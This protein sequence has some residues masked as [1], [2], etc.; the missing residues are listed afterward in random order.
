[1]SQ[2]VTE[3]NVPRL[4][5]EMSNDTT[6]IGYARV[7]RADQDPQLQIDALKRAGCAKIFVDHMTGSHMDRPQLTAALEYVRRGDTLVLWKMDRAGRNTRGV[8]ELVEDLTRRGVGLRSITEEID[9][10][11]PMGKAILTVML[12]FGT[13]ERDVLI[14]RTRA[15]LDAARARGRVGG[16]PTVVSA[17]K[18]EAAK[19]LIRGGA[20]VTAAAMAVNV[21]RSSLY[22]GLARTDGRLPNV[23]T[24]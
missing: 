19:A 8:L 9:T 21:S 11:G 10:S 24:G 2:L 6:Q 15:G 4:E 16:R 17:H 22:R 18:L 7:S 23:G 14:E 1:V 20:T 3:T 5:T 12:A 13:L